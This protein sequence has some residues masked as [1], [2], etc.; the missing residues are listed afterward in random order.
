MPRKPIT[1]IGSIIILAAGI[2]SAVSLFLSRTKFVP[3]G[4]RFNLVTIG[5]FVALVITA[6]VVLIWYYVNEK[7]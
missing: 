7:Q 6:I 2:F 3:A 1:W 4:F 5:S